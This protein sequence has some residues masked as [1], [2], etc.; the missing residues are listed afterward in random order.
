MR[1][2][3]IFSQNVQATYIRGIPGVRSSFICDYG[4][5]VKEQWFD[6]LFWVLSAWNMCKMGTF[7]DF[8][9]SLQDAGL[10]LGGIYTTA[11]IHIEI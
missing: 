4:N 3:L 11:K 9:M 8:R 1:S 2:A 7:F 5:Q 6:M 10:E